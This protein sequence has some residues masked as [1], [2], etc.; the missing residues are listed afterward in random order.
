[1]SIHDLA[2]SRIATQLC[3]TTQKVRG[4]LIAASSTA[5]VI[6][7]T[8]IVPAK[9]EGL[10][11]SFSVAQQH[12]MILC[13]LLLVI[14]LLASFAIFS[15][16]DLVNNRL[17]RQ[18]NLEA[19]LL[20]C[21]DDAVEKYREHPQRGEAWFAVKSQVNTISKDVSVSLRTVSGLSRVCFVWDVILPLFISVYAV[22]VLSIFL[23]R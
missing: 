18:G 20:K 19:A 8:G 22:T 6:F 17:Q 5:I 4:R 9:I 15:M 23:T 21:V 11:I 13:L 12:S 7:H 1:M 16:S 2:R 14:F 3:E 10:G